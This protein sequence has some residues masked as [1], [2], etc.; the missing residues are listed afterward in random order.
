[1]IKWLAGIIIVIFGLGIGSFL[2]MLV[3]RFDDQK[4][5][6]FD[7]K[8]VFGVGK[9]W[10]RSRCDSCGR[11]LLW[12]E[13][14]PVVSFLVLK[15]RCR[16]CRSPIPFWFFLIELATGISFFLTYFYWLKNSP[17]S[18]FNL[19]VYL[20]IASVLIFIF[21]YDALYQ[22]IPD[23]VVL[24]LILS[25]LGNL[26]NLSYLGTALGAAGFFLFLN[27]VTRGQ[28]MGLGDVKFAFFMGLFLGFPKIIFAFYLA[29]LTGALWG[30]IL[31]LKKKKKFGQH[32]A[33][34]PFLVMGTFV[35]WFWGDIF[36]EIIKKWY[37]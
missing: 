15:G 30:V 14:I 21:F 12:W 24:I 25:S 11:K 23:F 37:F 32:I 16:T 5:E 17:F 6:K 9:R 34:G 28:G 26:I 22:I 27:L 8:R 29:F 19:L 10:R 31:I 4:Q 18:Y 3:T 13:N 33:F 7:W 20:F 2:G 35:G 36:L 1:M